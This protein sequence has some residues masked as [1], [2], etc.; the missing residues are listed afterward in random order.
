MFSMGCELLCANSLD[1]EVAVVVGEVAKIEPLVPAPVGVVGS[2]GGVEA[3][4]LVSL[5]VGLSS[6][7][8]GVVRGSSRSKGRNIA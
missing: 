2:F 7:K 6:N 1:V 5:M 3:G 8:V 4:E